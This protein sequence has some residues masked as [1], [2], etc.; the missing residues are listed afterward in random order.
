MPVSAREHGRHQVEGVDVRTTPLT[1]HC[2]ALEFLH[3]PTKAMISINDPCSWALPCSATHGRLATCYCKD[4][5][6]TVH[7]ICWVHA[8]VWLALLAGSFM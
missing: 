4:F 6:V 1:Q 2:C 3:I 5:I 8:P 7:V